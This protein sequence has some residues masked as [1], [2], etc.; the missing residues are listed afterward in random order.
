MGA[1]LGAIAFGSKGSACNP[2]ARAFVSPRLLC[3]ETYRTAGTTV[4]KDTIK[5]RIAEVIDLEKKNGDLIEVSVYFT[6]LEDAISFGLNDRVDFIPASLLKLPLAMTLFEIAADDPGILEE[7]VEFNGYPKGYQSVQPISDTAHT[8]REGEKYRVRDVIRRMLIY[9]DNASY[10]TLVAYLTNDLGK[11]DVLHQTYRDLGI[12]NP[13]GDTKQPAVN[14]KGFASIFRQLYHASFLDEEV[15]TLLL[16]MLA[17]SNYR[18]GLQ[19]GVPPSVTVAHKYG[20]RILDD[21]TRSLH[22][23]G[24]VYHTNHPYVLCI[25]TKGDNFDELSS[26]I[27]SISRVVYENVD[28]ADVK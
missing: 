28:S 18:N 22:D 24:I 20:A 15:S 8:I 5:R 27:A 25:M 11:L 23:C 17:E 7:H 6:D 1:V 10:I 12:L 2:S 4:D 3:G 21:S 26:A 14:A 9:S 16:A 13:N 19:A